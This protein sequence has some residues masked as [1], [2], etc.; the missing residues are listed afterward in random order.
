MWRAAPPSVDALL[1]LTEFPEEAIERHAAGNRPSM[2]AVGAQ[3][4]VTV[5]QRRQRADRNGLLPEARVDG[6]GNESFGGELQASLFEAPD[7]RHPSKG[8]SFRQLIDFGYQ[9]WLLL[10]LEEG[11]FRAEH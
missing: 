8:F 10:S 2:T 5:A 7:D 11:M 9:V 3:H 1:A 4:A 6:A